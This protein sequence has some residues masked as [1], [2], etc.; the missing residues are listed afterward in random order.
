MS[1]NAKFRRHQVVFTTRMFLVIPRTSYVLN[2]TKRIE[3]SK[4]AKY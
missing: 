1:V 2:D 4:S 3:R